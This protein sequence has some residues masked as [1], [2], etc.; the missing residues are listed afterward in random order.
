MS[1]PASLVASKQRRRALTLYLL[2]SLVGFSVCSSG[3]ASAN[4][5]PASTIGGHLQIDQFSLASA[6]APD[7]QLACGFNVSFYGYAVG[8]QHASIVVTP[9]TPTVG[10]TPILVRAIWTTYTRTSANQLD[11]NVVVSSASLNDAFAGATLAAQGYHAMIAIQVSNAHTSLLTFHTV[12]ISSCATNTAVASAAGAS[13][14]STSASAGTGTTAPSPFGLLF[15]TTER[16]GGTNVAFRAGPVRVELG[17]QLQMLMTMVNTGTTTLVVQL[18]NATCDYLTLTPSSPQ[19]VAPGT[20]LT[21]FCSHALFSVPARHLF[22]DVATAT[23]LSSN[24]GSLTKV[25]AD[26]T[27]VVVAPSFA[28]APS[29]K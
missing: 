10:G 5:L 26:A 23:V 7:P 29:T 21:F 12:W 28:L 1:G 20:S 16:V 18:T 17:Q 19:S 3:V 25:S 8:T 4:T 13:T 9:T 6:S 15:A 27:A 22:K 2:L 11:Q 14:S 24:G